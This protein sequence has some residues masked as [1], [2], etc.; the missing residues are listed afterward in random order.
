MQDV[1]NW[2]SMAMAA[3]GAPTISATSPNVVEQTSVTTGGGASTNVRG[4]QGDAG[5]YS[6]TGA[7]NVVF[8][9]GTSAAWATAG[10][11]LRSVAAATE[12]HQTRRVRT[13]MGFH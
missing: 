9:L 1:N 8:T 12:R 10:I 4:G 11:E 6:T 7:H 3:T 2:I 5:A 13:V